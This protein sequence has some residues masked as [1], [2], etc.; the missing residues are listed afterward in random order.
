MSAG[1]PRLSFDE[2]LRKLAKLKE[3]GIISAEEYKTKKAEILA[4]IGG[5]TDTSDSPSEAQA[6]PVQAVRTQ[7]QPG[8]VNPMSGYLGC[9]TIVFI[10]MVIGWLTNMAGCTPNEGTSTFPGMTKAEFIQCISPCNPLSPQFKGSLSEA[11]FRKKYGRPDHIQRIGDYTYWYYQCKDGEIQIV[12]VSS[13]LEMQGV[14]GI[15][16]INEF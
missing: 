16:E 11:E 7:V 15:W 9:L 10:L 5:G 3:D 2:H 6:R 12:I 1:K 4:C 8:L 13:S 14:V